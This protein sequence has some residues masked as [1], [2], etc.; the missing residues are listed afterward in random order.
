MD[1]SKKAN[2]ATGDPLIIGEPNEAD[3]GDGTGL[4]ASVEGGSAFHVTN[5]G[6]QG[7]TAIHGDGPNGATGLLGTSTGFGPGVHGTAISGTAVLAESQF[8]IGVWGVAPGS[9]PAVVAFSG[10][11][12][13]PEPPV[14]DGGLALAVVGKAHF[15]TGGAG[16]VPARMSMATVAN[17]AVTADSH[18]TV[19]LTGNPGR[20]SVTWV[21]RQPGTGFIVHLSG[22]PR[23]DVPFTYLIVETNTV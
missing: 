20:A 22:S 2:A 10:H 9:A 11:L 1:R 12:A 3:P 17:P 19:T 21:E 16:L 5:P 18:I 23:S 14:Q 13:Y 7:S 8:G 4:E 6:G 15:S